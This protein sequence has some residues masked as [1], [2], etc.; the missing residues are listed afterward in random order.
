MGGKSSQDARFTA[1]SKPSIGQQLRKKKK[2]ASFLASSNRSDHL[3]AG[4]C[5]PIFSR[6]EYLKGLRKWA[7]GVLEVYG[8]IPTV[9][10]DRKQR[11]N[12]IAS[13]ICNQQ[14]QISSQGALQI[15]LVLFFDLPLVLS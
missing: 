8:V 6:N 13:R 15:S 4:S 2:R 1:T 9:A 7:I 10:S 3:H 12:R 14:D 11:G 5:G